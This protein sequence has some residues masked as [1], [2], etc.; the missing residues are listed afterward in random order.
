MTTE[1]HAYRK[2]SIEDFVVLQ[3]ERELIDKISADPK[4]NGNG[5]T[6]GWHDVN[7]AWDTYD[8]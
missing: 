7:R 3:E 4:L 2:E 8:M 5:T 6:L 1:K